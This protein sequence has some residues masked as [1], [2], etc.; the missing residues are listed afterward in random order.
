VSL[1]VALIIKVLKKFCWGFFSF[2]ICFELW[3]KCR[4]AKW[5]WKCEIAKQNVLCQ[6]AKM[7]F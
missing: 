3:R 2:N 6:I 5:N 4:V 1:N 7:K